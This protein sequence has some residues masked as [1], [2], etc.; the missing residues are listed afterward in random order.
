MRVGTK[1]LLFGVHQFL[2]H[3]LTVALAWKRVYTRWPNWWECVAICCHD[4]GYWGKRDMD[5]SDGITHPWGGARIAFKVVMLLQRW[6]KAPAE[7]KLERAWRAWELCITHSAGYCWHWNASRGGLLKLPLGLLALPDKVCVL[8]DPRWFYLLRAR[9]SGEIYEF[10]RHAPAAVSGD[11]AT[12][13]R[14]Y[15][16]KVHSRLTQ[17]DRCRS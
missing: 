16:S 1:S 10:M 4:L 9:L 7:L 17:W 11:P 2:Y 15:R 14:W 6:S 5:G 8:Y 12:W 13:L 3:P